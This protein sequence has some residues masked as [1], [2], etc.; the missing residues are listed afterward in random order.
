MSELTL[1]M[2]QELADIR[3]RYAHGLID[4]ETVAELAETA[5]DAELGKPDEAINSA[6]LDACAELLDD[7]YKEKLVQF[8]DH[9][10]DTWQAIHEGISR[11]E[12]QH[13]AVW[14]RPALRVA[15]CLALILGLSA[16]LP[17]SWLRGSQTEDGQAHRPAS[18]ETILVT[19]AKAEDTPLPPPA[20]YQ[21]TDFAEVSA[22]LG[23]TPPMPAWLPDEW[24]LQTYTAERGDQERHFSACYAKAG[25]EATLRYEVTWP[26]EFSSEL[27]AGK[28]ITLAQ[29]QTIHLSEN[30]DQL[31]AVWTADGYAI[32]YSGP[33]TEADMLQSILSIR[34]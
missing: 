30:G 17:L 31:L 13:H 9:R 18:Y 21:T 1:Q 10:E 19:E 2:R 26:D 25:E 29:G 14:F 24:S 7:V 16:A 32:R 27:P 20:S 28:E 8:P 11:L 23:R 12:K 15:A 5:I 22:F 3:E 6:W 34:P 33:L 4:A